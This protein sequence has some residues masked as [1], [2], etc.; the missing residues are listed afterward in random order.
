MAARP[1]RRRALFFPP[2]LTHFSFLLLLL[3]SFSH[4]SRSGGGEQD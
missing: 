3:L 2:S 4:L 1:N